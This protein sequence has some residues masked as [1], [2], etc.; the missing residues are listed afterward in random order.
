[1]KSFVLAIDASRNNFTGTLVAV[2][3]LCGYEGKTGVN[4]LPRSLFSK[5]TS[6]LYPLTLKK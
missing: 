3:L 6:I 5:E 1:V 2:F 4:H